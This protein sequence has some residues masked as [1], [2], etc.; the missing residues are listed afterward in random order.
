MSKTRVRVTICGAEYSFVS[1]DSSEYVIQIA[2]QVDRQ[3]TTLMK[4]NPWIS[5]NTAAVYAAVDAL[6]HARQD[7][8][9]AEHL[10][11]QMK[12]YLADS[13]R[14]RSE[15]EEARREIERLREELQKKDEKIAALA[16]APARGTAN[17]GNHNNSELEDQTHIELPSGKLHTGGSRAKGISPD[18]FI[19]M[20]DNLSGKKD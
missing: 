10:R 1:D 11:A 4:Q 7:Q 5:L 15:A 3:I 16:A 2:E 19:N 12:E 17:S 6:D 13:A 8:S 14:C 18:E 9:A 20:I